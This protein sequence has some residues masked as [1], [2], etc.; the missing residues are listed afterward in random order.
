MNLKVVILDERVWLRQ[1]H[2]QISLPASELPEL[3]LAL[4]ERARLLEF[5]QSLRACGALTRRD[6]RGDLDPAGLVAA[7]LDE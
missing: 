2:R 4:G 6:G 1:E 3:R 7:F 5:A